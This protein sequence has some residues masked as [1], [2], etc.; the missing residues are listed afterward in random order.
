MFGKP[1]EGVHAIR[2]F[3]IAIIDVL[4]TLLVAIVITLL[5]GWNLFAVSI[6]LFVIGIVA[7]RLFCVKT[8]VDRLIFGTSPNA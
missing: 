3:D 7:H 5:T 6:C 4:A 2:V 8:K 1:G